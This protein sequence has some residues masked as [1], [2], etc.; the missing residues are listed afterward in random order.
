MMKV[1]GSFLS[2][3]K[4]LASVMLGQ[5]ESLRKSNSLNFIKTFLGDACF[6]FMPKFSER[7]F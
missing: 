7:P 6:V 2:H 5:V 3:P 4:L 1:L